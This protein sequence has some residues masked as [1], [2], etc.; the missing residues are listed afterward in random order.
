MKENEE[1]VGGWE[2][3]GTAM[4]HGVEGGLCRGR[5]V[6]S[7]GVG[8]KEEQEWHRSMRMPKGNPLFRILT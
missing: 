8:H 4:L 5:E 6:T 2:S 7:R 3:L 1:M